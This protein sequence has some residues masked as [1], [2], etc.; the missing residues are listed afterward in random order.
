MRDDRD[1]TVIETDG[2][3]GFK[4]FVLGAIVGAG[5]GMLFAPQSGERTRRD[6]ARRGRKLRSQARE[7]IEEFADDVES[8][9]RQLKE[10]VSEFADDVMEEVSE[11]RHR[12]E[13]TA[14][15]AERQVSSAREEME[16]RLADARARARASAGVDD[17][18]DED[19]VESD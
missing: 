9:G 15:R 10:S 18:A 12:A 6:L 5:V 3:S 13:R 4:W 7:K 14:E 19:D 11:K 16:R 8:R 1:V 2:G 17:G